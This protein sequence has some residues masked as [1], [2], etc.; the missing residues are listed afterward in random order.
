VLTKSN[1]SILRVLGICLIAGGGSGNI[2]DR[3]VYGSVTDF[4]Q[5]D[6]VFFH[7]GIFNIADVSIMAGIFLIIVEIVTK[8]IKLYHEI[9]DNQTS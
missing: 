6:F 7:T 8:R 1:L 9:S 4:L 3:L 2:Y 5:F